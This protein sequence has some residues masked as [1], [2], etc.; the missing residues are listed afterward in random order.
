M[1]PAFW[2]TSPPPPRNRARLGAARA[3]VA[4]VGKEPGHRPVS[5][6]T[7]AATLPAQ[8]TALGR[9]LLAFSPPGLVEMII[10]R[11]LRPYTAHTI[12]SPE[13]FRRA[14]ALTRFTRVTPGEA[15]TPRPLRTPLRR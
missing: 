12:T 1:H 2:R 11:G 8:P 6:F 4:Y 13:R 10:L 5:G 9:A 14:L 15:P 7:P 3:Q